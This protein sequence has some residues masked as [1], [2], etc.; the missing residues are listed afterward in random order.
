MC[1]HFCFRF[2][3]FDLN[4]REHIKEYVE[5]ISYRQRAGCVCLFFCCCCCC[6]LFVWRARR[7]T[8]S[9]FLIFESFI[10]FNSALH[11]IVASSSSSCS[12]CML[13]WFGNTVCIVACV[14]PIIFVLS[15]R[16]QASRYIFQPKET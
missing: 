16:L 13:N 11:F 5:T 9:S 6:S 12:V 3:S 10:R 2:A 15:L 8:I 7:R 14:S 1:N 4:A